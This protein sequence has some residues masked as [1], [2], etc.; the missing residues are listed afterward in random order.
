LLPDARRGHWVWKGESVIAI[1][2]IIRAIDYH[3]PSTVLTNAH[4]AQCYPDWPAEKVEDKL[5]V[6]TRHIAADGECASD[7]GVQAA[8]QLF[9]SGACIPK[10]VDFLLFCTQSPD[11]F[12]PTTACIIQDR[13]G[14]PKTGGAL[15]FN[16]GCSGYIYGLS[17]AKGLIE[18]NQAR[19]VL[20]I[21]AETYSKYIHPDD[22]TVRML[23]GDAGAATLIGSTNE[24]TSDGATWMGPFVFGTDGSGA[25]HLIVRSGA[26]RKPGSGPNSDSEPRNGG[27]CDANL[28][29]NGPEIFTFTLSTVSRSV[30]ELLQ[31]TG[32][33]LSDVDLFVFHQASKLVLDALRRK[34]DIADD[35]FFVYLRDVGNTVSCTIPIALR[36]AALGGRLKSGNLVMLVG[37]GVGLSWSA[38]LIRWH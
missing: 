36:E 23:F 5:G 30:H 38:T 18:T 28:Y 27:R 29:M 33:K 25:E 8:K 21:T 7:L 32:F 11:Y 9:A 1:H 34:C 10:E 17:L 2:A 14:L 16:L 26:A 37:F 24:A 4:L 31:K 6:K 3:L 15:D 22:R 19:N 20:L 12:L 35:R 13:L